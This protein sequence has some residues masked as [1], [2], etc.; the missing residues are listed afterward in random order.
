[1]LGVAG[2][3]LM[4]SKNTH[5]ES[6]DYNVNIAPS[7]NVSVTSGGVATSSVVLNLNPNSK[8][9]DSKSVD[10]K[11]ATNNI[12]GYQL[13]VST[14]N[15]STDLDR[16][17]TVDSVSATIPT[18]ATR[19]GGY[20]DSDFRNCTTS[21]CTNKWGYKVSASDTDPSLVT[22]N[23]FPFTQNINLATN[24]VAT[25]G[26][27]TTLDFA[28]KIDYN[29]PAGTYKN[30]LVFTATATYAAYDIN[31]YDGVNNSSTIAT[32]SNAYNTSSTIALNPQYSGGATGPTRSGLSGD[33]YTFVKWCDQIPTADANNYFPATVCPGNSYDTSITIDPTQ[34][35]TNINL[36]AYWDPT[37]FDEA[38][39]AA[40]KTKSG[41][42]YM[43]QDM[44][45]NLCHA[46]TVN[47]VTQLTDTR[48]G[49]YT[50]Y[51][52]KLKD[53]KCWMTQNL[54]LGT[55]VSSLTLTNADSNIS[56]S[57]WTLNG[58]VASPG[59][60]T[61]YTSCVTGTCEDRHTSTTYY[62]DNNAYYCA[63]D[64]AS[65][66]NYVGCYYNWYSA[67]ASSG[68]SSITPVG[69]STGYK[70]VSSSICP[71]NWY[72]PSGGG[73]PLSGSTSDRSDSDFNVLYNNYPSATAMLV[74]N[75]TV[76]TSTD[77]RGCDNTSGLPRPGLLLSGRYYSGGADGVAQYGYY[78]SRSAYSK[79]MAY[80]LNLN[81][82][83][84]GPQYYGVK[85][86]GM[87]V[88]CVAYGS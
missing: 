67:T 87:S 33:T 29:Q 54:K 46:V 31:Y 40:G 84:V 49:N 17:A 52:A 25:N 63:P 30:T 76:C 4:G 47:E 42:Y 58:K 15:S 34:Y 64:S 70:D 5:A 88:R 2:L 8:T 59:K 45:A 3:A 82:S 77:S 80:Y 74:D 85:Y 53:D 18:L 81:S 21:D 86:H 14:S 61:T 27:N 1:M 50:Y 22:V 37:T 28:A 16:D 13:F 69:T 60:F 57:S 44:D 65:S 71:K 72:L 6:V 79:G 24:H 39:L 12:T 9:F 78:W 43:M 62:N 35:S 55:N 32:Q 83:A 41:S 23:Y 38:Y 68:T 75:P 66:N 51:I 48:S 11:V 73:V 7:L 20:S 36:Y 56:A 10:I 19:S 26:D